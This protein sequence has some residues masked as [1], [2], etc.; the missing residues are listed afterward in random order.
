[1]LDAGINAQPDY[2]EVKNIYTK[3]QNG[4]EELVAK[5]KEN[6]KSVSLPCF[7]LMLPLLTSPGS[8]YT[9][10]RACYHVS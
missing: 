10:Q 9:S 1:M 2:R 4:F 8:W 3:Y 5:T 7:S 6:E